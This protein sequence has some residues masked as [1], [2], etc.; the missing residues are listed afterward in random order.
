MDN[1]YI[2]VTEIAGDEVTQEQLDR[3]CNR[4][5]WA[6]QYCRGKD[7]VETACGS[8]QGLSYLNGI[9][10]SLEAGDYSE[11]MIEIAKVHYEDRINLQQFDAQDMPFEDQSKDVIILFEAL[12]YLPDPD[13]FVWECVRVLRPKGK[14]LICTANKDL[15]DFNPSPYSHQ[16]FG[17]V[18]L[19]DLFEPAGVTVKCFGG[20]PVD[21]VALRQKLLR[22][23]KKL[24]V[25]C[26]LI[27]KTTSG[28]KWIKRIVFGD[29]VQMPAE[30][31]ENTAPYILPI[32]L[33]ITVPDKK[34]KVLFC[35]ATKSNQDK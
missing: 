6:G 30:I 13:K 34:H 12:Y 17:I 2:S 15:Y 23:I 10:K 35:E 33:D 16:Y 25:A 28:K 32:L 3:L 18:E 26:H 19:K 22:P 20:A 4:Y 11:K 24:A 29:L 1:D 14:V 21:N 9:A 31:N 27:P 8:G 5:F 7:V